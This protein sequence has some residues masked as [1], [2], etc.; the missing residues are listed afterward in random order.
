MRDRKQYHKQWRLEHKQQIK[1]YSKEWEKT[2]KK[3]RTKYKYNYNNT[4]EGR[5]RN[6]KGNAKTRGFIFNLTFNEFSDMVTK[7]CYY[8]GDVSYGVDRLDSSLGYIQ[9]NI[10]SC[11]SMCNRMKQIYTEEE[12]INQCIKISE[13]NKGEGKNE[14]Y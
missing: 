11:C 6:Y 10:V 14:L 12:F 5:F 7:P 8:C 13:Y 3:H 1:E 9:G 2:N 4:L